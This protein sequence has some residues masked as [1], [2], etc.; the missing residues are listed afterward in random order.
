MDENMRLLI[1]ALDRMTAAH[2]E[3]ADGLFACADA[4]R[5]EPGSDETEQDA[6]MA[7]RGMGM[8]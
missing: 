1:E 2:Q 4:M 3:I 6:P 5:Q 8:G 7:G